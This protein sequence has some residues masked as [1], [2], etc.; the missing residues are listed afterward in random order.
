MERE[1]A[2]T[3]EQI[4]AIIPHREPFIFIDRIVEIEYGKRAVGILDDLSKAEH[5][6]WLKGHFPSFPVLPGAILVE[7]LAEVGA[8][9][10]LGLPENRGK[11]AILTGLDRWRFR[12]AVQ[13]G[14]QVRL[15]AEL[16]RM[17]QRFGVGHLRA[18]G[19]D[20][21]IIA[22]GDMSFAI[23]DPPEG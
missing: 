15:E 20:G 1:A 7:A 3:R 10:A 22:E 4:Q 11:V 14:T 16:T 6:F 23:V 17:R 9:A 2:L 21:K 19:A 18:V 8:V 12:Q 13:P 5:Q